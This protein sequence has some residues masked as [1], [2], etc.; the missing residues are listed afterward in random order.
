MILL[1]NFFIIWNNQVN[2]VCWELPVHVCIVKYTQAVCSD[3]WHKKIHT[4]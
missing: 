3:I 4:F 2:I 1:L